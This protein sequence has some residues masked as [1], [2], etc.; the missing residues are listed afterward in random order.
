MQNR[1]LISLS[2]ARRLSIGHNDIER[3]EAC[4]TAP[5]VQETMVQVLLKVPDGSGRSSSEGAG[6]ASLSMTRAWR[7]Y[8]CNRPEPLVTDLYSTQLIHKASLNNF[9]K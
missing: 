6:G 7:F 3:S 4:F 2:M 9:T 1:D 5:I 8:F